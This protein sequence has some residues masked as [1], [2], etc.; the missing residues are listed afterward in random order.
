VPEGGLTALLGP[1]GSGKSTLLRIIAGL[2]EPD[3]G[4][5]RIAGRDV[6]SARPQDRGIGFV[7]QP[8]AAFAHMSVFDNVAFGLKIRKR[9]G[10][11]VRAKVD[12]LLALVG[13]TQWSRQRPHQA[14]G[15]P[16]P[17]NGP[18]SGAGRRAAGP[19]A[20]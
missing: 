17:A 18:G 12:E 4:Q 16:T 9:K 15:R 11:E 5:V 1:S 10:A 3:G 8:Y 2:E 20:R 14:L 6:T 13:L 19:V 7:F